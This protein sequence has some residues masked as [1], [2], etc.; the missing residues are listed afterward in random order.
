[1]VQN[2]A[3]AKIPLE[4]VWIDIPYMDKYADFSIDTTAFPS[5]GTFTTSMHA[6]NQKVVPIL[7]AGL[8]ADNLQDK[9]YKLAQTNKALI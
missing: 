4:A 7:D 3:D 5:L 6:K 8:S 1:M 2:Y 9:Y